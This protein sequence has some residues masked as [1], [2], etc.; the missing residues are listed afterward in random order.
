[1]HIRSDCRNSKKHKLPQPVDATCLSPSNVSPYIKKILII[2]LAA[3]GDVLRT[4]PILRGLNRKYPQNS[5]TWITEKESVGLLENNSSIDRLL[6]YDSANL[7]LLKNEEFDILICL[8]K[9][10]EATT[11]VSQLSAKEKLGFGID[12]TTDNLIA[13]NKASEYALELGLSDE[14]KFKKNRKTYPEIVFEMAELVYQNDEYI[15]N[16]SDSDARYAQDLLNKLELC[17]NRVIIGL[18]TGAGSRFVNKAWTEEGFVELIRLIRANLDVE[19]L[20]LGGPQER[21]RNIRIARQALGLAHNVGCDHSF[22]QFAA[23]ESKCCLIVSGDTAALH[24]AVAL[25]KLVV[26]LFGSTCDQEIELYGRGVKV[27][28]SMECRP[29]YKNSCDKDVNCMN[30]ITAAEVFK[31]IE[32]IM[33]KC[34]F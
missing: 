26:A 19:I 13:L 5:I 25:G 24:I 18:D 27:A 6:C 3:V 4:T 30:S 12:T 33:S 29:C 32:G 28:S 23:I 20:L 14:L 9:E 2:K 31:S 21:Q 10:R 22:R 16:I 15:L 8:D 7:E 1:M 11:L 34:K 17:P